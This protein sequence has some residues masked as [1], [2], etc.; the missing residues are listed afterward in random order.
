MSPAQFNQGGRFGT[1][2]QQTRSFAEAPKPVVTGQQQQQQQ[3]L[4][5]QAPSPPAYGEAI[6]SEQVAGLGAPTRSLG[7]METF[8]W[9]GIKSSK[10]RLKATPLL[11]ALKHANL[12]PDEAFNVRG[13]Y[14]ESATNKSA[15]PIGV[16]LSAVNGKDLVKKQL[17]NGQWATFILPPGVTRDFQHMND[18]KGLLLA[19]NQLDDFGNVNVQSLAP[20]DLIKQATVRRDYIDPTTKE[21]TAYQVDVDLSHFADP[22]SSLSRDQ[23]IGSMTQLGRLVYA[24]AKAVFNQ[25]PGIQGNLHDLPELT[26]EDVHGAQAF[27]SIRVTEDAL[28]KE[29]GHFQAIID[30]NEL[31]DAVYAYGNHVAQNAQPTR[32]MDHTI[33]VFRIGQKK[34]E[35]IGDLKN[36]IGISAADIDRAKQA[37]SGVHVDL[38]YD[39]QHN[40]QKFTDGPELN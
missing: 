19:E 31:R 7:V 33:T 3:Q 35:H 32:A 12:S 28:A 17:A 2:V 37:Y 16:Q 24:N 25:Y 39:I 20:E 14:L 13:V 8:K 38:N 27:P 36:E 23:K 34:D 29:R 22:Q 9:R 30:A 40:G 26:D 11:A 6:Q 18:G 1:P 5:Q 4:Q 15:S 10:D 21:P